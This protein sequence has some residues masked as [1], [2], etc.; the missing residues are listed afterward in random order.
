[1]V[2]LWL[3]LQVLRPSFQL[4]TLQFWTSVYLSDSTQTEEQPPPVPCD[5]SSSDESVD[6]QKLVK[7]RSCEDIK[8]AVEHAS[9][10]TRR[11]SDPN[12][13]SD[14]SEML[15]SS[16]Q[17][18]LATDGE[19][20][21]EITN[22]GVKFTNK[23]SDS[24]I[25]NSETELPNGE[26][27]VSSQLNNAQNGENCLQ[28]VD[29]NEVCELTTS[30]SSVLTN[31]HSGNSSE[32]DSESC[33]MQGLNQNLTSQSSD[34]VTDTDSSSVTAKSVE[35]ST[36]TLIGDLAAL[37][38]DVVRTCSQKGPIVANG[39]VNEIASKQTCDRYPEDNLTLDRWVSISTSTSDISDSQVR[40]SDK[41][42]L[43]NGA[44]TI[45]NALLSLQIPD[46]PALPRG[47]AA[48]DALVMN[49]LFS[50]ESLQDSVETSSSGTPFNSRT[51]SSTNPPTPAADARV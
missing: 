3:I 41:L 26:V 45:D 43:P 50:R 9:G 14:L 17:E 5:E 42:V 35:S 10:T 25:E 15:K 31:G 23:S 22:D 33:D 34:V 24:E 12:I 46:I 6:N 40:I 13:T 20:R 18:G 11:Q 38:K 39:N 28:T 21:L 29:E 8:A 37:P 30:S 51:P 48:P 32:T 16:L 1:M 7:T 2:I 47:Q 4:K 49:G 36:D 19:K 27:D 44:L